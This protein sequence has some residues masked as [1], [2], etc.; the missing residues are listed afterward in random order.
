MVCCLASEP[1]VILVLS[2]AP[3]FVDTHSEGG[4]STPSD[5]TSNHGTKTPLFWDQ[6]H[7]Q[8]CIHPQPPRAQRNGQTGL[9]TTPPPSEPRGDSHSHPSPYPCFTTE[10]HHPCPTQLPGHRTSPEGT[11]FPTL[12]G[13]K[14]SWRQ[15]GLTGRA[16]GAQGRSEPSRDPATCS[17]IIR[18]VCFYLKY[19]P[20]T[21][22]ITKVAQQ[23]R[24]TVNIN[25]SV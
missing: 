3:N 25:R 18:L 14:G 22:R 15:S 17:V 6:P 13:S 16:G 23:Y 20:L 2:P 1:E 24:Q 12:R 11:T 21:S 19:Y 10:H 8:G 5:T 7:S 4:G 9:Q